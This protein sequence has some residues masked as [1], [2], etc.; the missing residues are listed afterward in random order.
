[1]SNPARTPR[2]ALALALAAAI[3][4]FGGAAIFHAGSVLRHF[5]TGAAPAGRPGAQLLGI[6]TLFAVTGLLLLGLA[7]NDLVGA[8][9]RPHAAKAAP[10]LPPRSS[11]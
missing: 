5:G 3:A 8:H 7:A 11:A 10:R 9:R 2:S 1:M 4:F 6:V